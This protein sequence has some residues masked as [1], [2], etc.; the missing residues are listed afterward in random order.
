MCNTIIHSAQALRLRRPSHGQSKA[1]PEWLE[2]WA[3]TVDD[4]ASPAAHRSGT[5][6][7]A[8]PAVPHAGAVTAGGPPPQR[9]NAPGGGGHDC[10]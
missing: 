3:I 6:T 1:C 4:P 2:S 10:Q 7:T 9:V 8:G 5:V